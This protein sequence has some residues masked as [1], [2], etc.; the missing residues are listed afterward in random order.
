MN[1]NEQKLERVNGNIRYYQSEI[2]VCQLKLE[3]MNLL[4]AQLEQTLAQEK[5]P[6]T[7]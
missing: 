7:A 1:E 2:A 3:A 4:K 5:A 6:P